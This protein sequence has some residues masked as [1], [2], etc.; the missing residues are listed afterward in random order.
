MDGPD[1]AAD[2]FLRERV[3]KRI[4]ASSAAGALPFPKCRPQE[5]HRSARDRDIGAVVVAFCKTAD[6]SPRFVTG[7]PCPSF[8]SLIVWRHPIGLRRRLP[9]R[10]TS[11]RADTGNLLIGFLSQQAFGSH[12]E[13]TRSWQRAAHCRYRGRSDSR[14]STLEG[15]IPQHG[16][17]DRGVRGRRR[18]PPAF[19]CPTAPGGIVMAARCDG[20][21]PSS[22][23]GPS[24]GVDCEKG[25][26]PCENILRSSF[27]EFSA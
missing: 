6:C 4:T 23:C 22:R 5:P 1:P 24:P 16:S 7:C 8:A 10:R 27:L 19:T 13:V 20:L 21:A 3:E 25:D 11:W 2:F 12:I 9:Q 26:E 14:T 15:S 18:E 17:C